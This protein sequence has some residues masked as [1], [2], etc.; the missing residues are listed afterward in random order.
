MMVDKPGMYCTSVL[1]ALRLEKFE[2]TAEYKVDAYI[3]TQN[4]VPGI[5]S[6]STRTGTKL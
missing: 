4:R 5:M 1:L 3:M 2:S 6:R